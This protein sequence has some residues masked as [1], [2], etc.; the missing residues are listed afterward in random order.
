[1]L[2]AARVPSALIGRA[3]PRDSALVVVR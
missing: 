3:V 2:A 1:V